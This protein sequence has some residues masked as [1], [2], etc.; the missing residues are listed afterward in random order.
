MISVIWLVS[1][2]FFCAEKTVCKLYLLNREDEHTKN[3]LNFISKI[4]ETEIQKFI[5]FPI[6]VSQGIKIIPIVKNFSS[7]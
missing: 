2:I 7:S 5:E 4:L 1:V 3:K 6:F